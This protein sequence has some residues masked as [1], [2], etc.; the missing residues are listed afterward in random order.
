MCH[1]QW[2]DVGAPLQLAV[3]CTGKLNRETTGM[4]KIHR[5]ENMINL[6]GYFLECLKSC[7]ELKADC[8][9]TSGS[10]GLL[11][12]SRNSSWPVTTRQLQSSRRSALTDNQKFTASCRR[13]HCLTAGCRN[14]PLCTCETS[15]SYLSLLPTTEGPAKVLPSV[16]PCPA[17]STSSLPPTA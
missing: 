15:T 8:S 2:N 5:S 6:P 10:A 14:L 13:C 11:T 1:C 16:S 4:L 9:P 7:G 17:T 3:A 12:L